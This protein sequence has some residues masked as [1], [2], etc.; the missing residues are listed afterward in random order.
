MTHNHAEDH[1]VNHKH[2]WLRLV[3][4]EETPPNPDDWIDVAECRIDSPTGSRSA[5]LLVEQLA[6]AGI[7]AKQSL[8]KVPDALGNAAAI[9]GGISAKN[10][11]RTMVSVQQRDLEPTKQ[12]LRSYLATDS[13]ADDTLDTTTRAEIEYERL[14]PEESQSL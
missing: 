12:F 11:I 6:K 5:E 13:A 4:L 7:I 3:G 9:D 2:P 14:H 8:Y 1:P 10:R